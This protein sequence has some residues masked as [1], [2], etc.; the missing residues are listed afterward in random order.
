MITIPEMMLNE[1]VNFKFLNQRKKFR[2][3]NPLKS[4]KTFT[5][6]E[7]TEEEQKCPRKSRLIVRLMY[8]KVRI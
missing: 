6:K 2:D 7:V 3:R 8:G 4:N 5:L 1:I